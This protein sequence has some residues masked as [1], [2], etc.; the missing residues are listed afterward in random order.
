VTTPIGAGSDFGQAVAIDSQGRIIVAGSS[1]NGSTTDFAVARYNANGSL[2]P[3]FGPAHDG[4][5]TTDFFGADDS[6]NSV[7]I[8]AQGRV[9]VAGSDFQGDNDF[10]VARYNDSGTLDTTFGPNHNG[11]VTVD[12]TPLGMDDDVA[13]AV[14]ID[15]QGRIVLAGTSNQGGTFDFALARL[16][17]DGSRDATF[18]TNPA[19]KQGEVTTPIGSDSDVANGVAIDSQD[20]IVAAGHAFLGGTAGDDF[21]LARYTP[22]GVLDTSFNGTGKVTTPFGTTVDIAQAV[23]IDSQ[24]RI[25]AV[26]R[27]GTGND[28][29]F[30]LARYTPGGTLDTSFNGSGKVTTPIGAGSDIARAAAIDPQGRVVASGKSSNGVNDDFALARYNANGTLDTSFNGSG[31]VTTPF[32]SSSQEAALGVAIDPAG[33]IVAAGTSSI[34]PN[35]DF[36]LARYIGDAT[37]PT[38]TIGSGPA[39]GGFTNDP[40]PTFQ[41]SSSEAGSSFACSFEGLS[42]PCT[43]PF[44]PAPLADGPHSFSLTGTDR[45]GNTSAATGR[46]FTVDTRKPELKIKGKTKVKTAGR[47]ARDKLKLK[48]NEPS[49]FTC[50]VD[51]KKAKS[52]KAKYKTPK[53]K[54]GKHKLKVTATDRAGNRVSKTKKL[55]VVRKR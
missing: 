39:S 4:K 17:G 31:K 52:C 38:V 1:S 12:F 6:A 16:N 24:G 33:R 53:L 22:G 48:A 14:A 46:H 49:T 20:R 10:A 7:A 2:D 32:G 9:V 37:P 34:G 21:A 15:S 51:R 35:G 18:G 36:A 3:S 40:T 55:K 25:V 5:V 19:P 13:T 26:G 42:A 8:D 11:K 50:R 54:L 47:K 41:F 23:S 27:A 28:T 44:T 45:A 43:S 29:D 30:A